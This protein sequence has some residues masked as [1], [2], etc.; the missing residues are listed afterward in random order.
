M[1]KV[2]FTLD[3][4]TVRTLRR[5]ADRTGRAQSLVVREAIAEYA[6]GGERLGDGER[7]RLLNAYDE[8]APALPRRSAADVKRELT[9]LRRAR[10]LA[11]RRTKTR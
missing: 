4:E 2:T 10:R 6:A 9:G 3:D 5:I 8:L 7:E 11:G 1:V